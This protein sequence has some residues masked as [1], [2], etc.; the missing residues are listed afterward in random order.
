[1][2]LL[3]VQTYKLWILPFGEDKQY[4]HPG[5][6]C[7]YISLTCLIDFSVIAMSVFWGF[8]W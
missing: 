7:K 6:E 3:H 2:D 1:M 8:N 4:E 5:D